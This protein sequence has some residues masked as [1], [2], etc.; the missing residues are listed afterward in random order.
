MLF[1]ETLIKHE[2]PLSVAMA[3]VQSC[4]PGDKQNVNTNAS[5]WLRTCC[6]SE[7]CF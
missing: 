3:S 4:S 2:I 7:R 6:T 1:T 5:V